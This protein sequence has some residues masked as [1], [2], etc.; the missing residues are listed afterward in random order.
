[1]FNKRVA[2]KKWWSAVTQMGEL[3][4]MLKKAGRYYPGRES[5]TE[6]HKKKMKNSILAKKSEI[7]TVIITI[8]ILL[9]III[10]DDDNNNTEGWPIAGKMNPTFLVCPN[11]NPG[12]KV[13]GDFSLLWS[14]F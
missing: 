8:I 4:G 5:N 14:F 10:D 7:D 11:Y 6:H 1:M 13:L 9:L 3:A 2:K 12:Q